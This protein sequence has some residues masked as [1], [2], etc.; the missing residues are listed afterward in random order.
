MSLKKIKCKCQ[1]CN[2]SFILPIGEVTCHTNDSGIILCW[3]CCKEEHYWDDKR[4]PLCSDKT[5]C[6]GRFL[7]NL[8]I[9][10]ENIKGIS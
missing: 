9:H 7:K 10:V 5:M 8:K 2:L 3:K 6:R 1:S 4:C